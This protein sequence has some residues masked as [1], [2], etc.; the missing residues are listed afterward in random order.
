[1]RFP[2]LAREYGTAFETI[3]YSDVFEISHCYDTQSIFSILRNH[4]RKLKLHSRSPFKISSFIISYICTMDKLLKLGSQV[5]KL[6]DQFPRLINRRE[7]EFS[8]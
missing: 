3:L 1:M 2:G 7:P 8:S 6:L 4:S 5:A